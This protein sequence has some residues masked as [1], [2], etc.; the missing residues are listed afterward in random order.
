MTV[1]YLTRDN[2]SGDMLRELADKD[3]IDAAVVIYQDAEGYHVQGAKMKS[4]DLCA[5]AML[6]DELA[7]QALFDDE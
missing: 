3:G 1:H 2:S 5:I 7:R 6:V 4:K